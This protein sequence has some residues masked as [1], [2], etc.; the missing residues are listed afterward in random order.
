MGGLGVLAAL[1]I[2][3]ASVGHFGQLDELGP[4][5]LYVLPLFVVLLVVYLAA[6]LFLRWR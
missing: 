5:Y 2:L 3:A 1:V 6:A 4:H